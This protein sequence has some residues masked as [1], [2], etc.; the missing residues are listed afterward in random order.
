MAKESDLIAIDEEYERAGSQVD[1]RRK[2]ER[3][4]DA[5]LEAA[6]ELF[7]KRGYFGVSIDEVTVRSGAK[8]SLILYYFKNKDG[9]WRAA[10]ERAA[11]D[12]HSLLK[13]KLSSRAETDPGRHRRNSIGA[14]LDGFVESPAFARM[15]VLEGSEPGP[16]LDWL[17]EHYG[18]TNESLGSP[19]H[20]ERLKTTL[21]RDALMAIF[22]AMS[23]LGPLMEASLAKVS[24]NQKAGVYPLS[25]SR[26]EELI[27]LMIRFADVYESDA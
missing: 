23:A 8:R 5:I 11:Q 19:A 7:G 1:R 2:G 14:W 18:H 3:S 13:G 10:A 15:L 24:G 26:R 22:L 6:V 4:K 16:R 12:F 9:L 27:D 21:L 17:I 25:K 20:E